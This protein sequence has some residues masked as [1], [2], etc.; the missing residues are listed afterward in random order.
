MY[1]PNMLADAG[2]S[3][4]PDDDAAFGAGAAAAAEA[5]FAVTHGE[6]PT[7][8]VDLPGLAAA[9]GLGALLVKDESGRHGL[10]SF[11]A[12]GGAHAAIRLALD[13]AGRRAG[14]PF[15]PEDLGTS[16]PQGG[17]PQPHN[18]L[19]HRRQSWP[20]G[21]GRGAAGGARAAVVFLHQGVREVRAD[22]IRAEGAEILRVAGDYD[23]SLAAV[24]RSCAAEGWINVSDMALPGQEPDPDPGDAG[25]YR[26]G[27][28]DP[29]PMRRPAADPSFPAGRRRRHGGGGCGTSGPGRSGHPAVGGGTRRGRLPAGERARRATT[30]TGDPCSRP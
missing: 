27:G 18:G 14:R 8:L 21:R 4:D 2:R 7:P 26:D 9:S 29:A 15:G 17:Y 1:L 11:K 3:L 16:R 30:A 6:G 13:E 20:V 10:G 25:L 23:D 12:L 19:C 28:G 22:A 24:A 5:L